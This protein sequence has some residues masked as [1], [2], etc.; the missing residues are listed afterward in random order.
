MTFYYAC[1]KS[2]VGEKMSSD[3]KPASGCIRILTDS[4]RKRNREDVLAKYNK[5][6]VNIGHQHDHWMEL[7]EALRA[8]THV[9]M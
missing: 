4:G 6:K 8:Q 3:G 5:A 7:N 2:V 9:E 1:A